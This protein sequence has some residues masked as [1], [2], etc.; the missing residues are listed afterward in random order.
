MKK[1]T[2]VLLIATL[3]FTACKKDSST[4]TSSTFTASVNGQATTFNVFQATLLR[5][6]GDNEKRMDIAGTSTDGSKQFIITLGIETATGNGMTVKSY[7]LNAFPE[8]DP[9]TPNI[10]ESATTQGF[11]T[12]STKMSGGGWL[13]DVY[14]EQGLFNLSSC[15]ST[16]HII[17]G[18]FQTTL[19][20]MTSGDIVVDIKD[21]KMSNI[22][23]TVMN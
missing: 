5:S 21:G 4:K 8:D 14:N 15:D 2:S 3:F 9:S 17:S 18:T 11:T 13:T 19:R 23:Y 16:N 20:D 7:V 1:S 12:Y 6:T 10:D 22:K